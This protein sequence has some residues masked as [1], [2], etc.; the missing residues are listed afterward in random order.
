[1]ANADLKQLKPAYLKLIDL[2]HE[3]RIQELGK[4]GLTHIPKAAVDLIAPEHKLIPMLK[5]LAKDGILG[6]ATNS[7][8]EKDEV[9]FT[10]EG[11]GKSQVMVVYC[12]KTAEEILVYKRSLIIPGALGLQVI[13]HNGTFYKMY[14]NGYDGQETLSDKKE[15]PLLTFLIKHADT[16]VERVQVEVEYGLT[17]NQISSALNSIRRKVE[18][19]GFL[20]E[21]VEMMLPRYGRSGLMFRRNF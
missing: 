13:S 6:S 16:P 17:S 12:L 5:Q 9:F 18:R 14:R 8:D 20:R 3:H 11:K 19:L 15:G 7:E 10:T 1:M 21:E 4:T 2:I